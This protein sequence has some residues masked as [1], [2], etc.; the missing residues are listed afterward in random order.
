[1]ENSFVLA[2]DQANF[3]DWKNGKQKPEMEKKPQQKYF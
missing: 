1:M 2:V 3:T